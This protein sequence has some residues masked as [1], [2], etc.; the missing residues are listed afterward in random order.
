MRSQDIVS[1]ITSHQNFANE[2]RLKDGL[3][4][5]LFW[6]D[7]LQEDDHKFKNSRIIQDISTYY[8][9]QTNEKF[10]IKS[11]QYSDNQTSLFNVK[12]KLSENEKIK[13]TSN[14]EVKKVQAK[15]FQTELKG[16]NQK[17]KVIEKRLL[18]TDHERIS[19]SDYDDN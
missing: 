12:S 10:E 2:Q 7:I 16:L 19:E 4:P 8:N 5:T 18:K 15:N 17:L 11:S 13:N 3:D 14:K 9:L 6:I 1:A